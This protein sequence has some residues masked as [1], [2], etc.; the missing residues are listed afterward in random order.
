MYV[1]DSE[2]I[3]GSMSCVWSYEDNNYGN[4]YDLNQYIPMPG[5]SNSY[6]LPLHSQ[7]GMGTGT[8][9]S[10][11]SITYH[12]GEPPENPSGEM[13]FAPPRDAYRM[14]WVRLN[15]GT[16]V[17]KNT[18]GLPLGVRAIN[19]KS[20]SFVP[21][22]ST[23]LSDHA[24]VADNV[25]N[26][27]KWYTLGT[28]SGASYKICIVDNGSSSTEFQS[29][30]YKK[31]ICDIGN[32]G[33]WEFEPQDDYGRGYLPDFRTVPNGSY[34]GAENKTLTYQ[35]F[36]TNSLLECFLFRLMAIPA[37][38]AP[39]L[40]PDNQ[41][42]GTITD[43]VTIHYSIPVN[44]ANVVVKIDGEQKSTSVSANG[45]YSF[46]LTPYWS[47]LSLA[48]HNLEFISTY[49][50]YKCGAKVT[51]TKSD[52]LLQITGTPVQT[53]RMSVSCVMK[54]TATVPS[55]ATI[56][57]EVTNDA[58][59][60]NPEWEIYAGSSHSFSNDS[61][62][63]DKWGVNWRVTID[64]SAGKSQAQLATGVG[65]GVILKGDFGEE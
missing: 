46:D 19:G 23:A 63:A 14:K 17:Q 4:K 32:A 64:N 3:D 60:Q 41:N 57:R 5:T 8:K 58:F 55:G 38:Q 18:V 6:V 53:D 65:M 25:S 21:G 37:S 34:A 30:S 9:S 62:T 15:D 27:F 59:D 52:A 10:V 36:N 39:V 11:T 42:L 12:P 2:I 1:L 43:P 29:S 49:N 44:G 20:S 47:E 31:Y 13:M 28:I 35:Q 33:G 61:K 54:D 40:T 26:L 16:L 24:T 51:F 45:N 7:V 48:T 56:T 22:S 50:G